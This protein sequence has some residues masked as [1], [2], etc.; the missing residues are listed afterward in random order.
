MKTAL[1]TLA[2]VLLFATQGLAQVADPVWTATYNFGNTPENNGFTRQVNGGVVT[3]V[4]GGTPANRRVEINSTNGEAIFLTSNVP[5]LNM[6]VGATVQMTVAVSGTGNAG[7]ELTFLDRAF[8]IQ[9]YANRITV[10]ILDGNGA[11][12]VSALANTGDTIIRATVSPDLTLRV[13]RNNLLISTKTLGPTTQPFQRV[14]WWGEEGGVQIFRQL[15]YYIGG[16][17]AP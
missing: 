11:Q 17:V 4:T 1:R 13:Y 10:A 2:L 14:L 7:V 8:G 5:S 15:A 12:E 3:T 9:V 6:N 16:A